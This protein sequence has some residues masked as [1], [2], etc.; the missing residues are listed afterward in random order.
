MFELPKQLKNLVTPWLAYP[1]IIKSSLKINRQKLQIFLEKKGIQTRTIFTGNILRQPIM[2]RRK[3]KKVK[4]A[5]INS[6]VNNALQNANK[7]LTQNVKN[8]IS[9]SLNIGKQGEIK[10]RLAN[11]MKEKDLTFYSGSLYSG[12]ITASSILGYG[13]ISNMLTK[14]NLLK[15]LTKI[16]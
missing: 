3:Y 12:L 11:L 1:V 14:R 2:K 15:E 9:T 8:K 6:Q 5:E 16:S 13:E 10:Q 7:S 4:N